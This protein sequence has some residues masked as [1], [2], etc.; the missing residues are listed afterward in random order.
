MN[1]A[2]CLVLRP[3]SE[4]FVVFGQEFR[5]KMRWRHQEGKQEAW[6]REVIFQQDEAWVTI[7]KDDMNAHPFIFGQFIHDAVSRCV[8]QNG[9]SK[10][11]NF[12][13][14]AHLELWNQY[15][16]T[17]DHAREASGSEAYP[18]QLRD[19]HL[20]VAEDR[21]NGAA[22]RASSQYQ[23]FISD[24]TPQAIRSTASGNK[25]WITLL[26]AW[27]RG[28]WMDRSNDWRRFAVGEKGQFSHLGRA[29]Q[30]CL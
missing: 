17:V 8:I 19:T 10:K 21:F 6:K 18:L 12:C 2:L 3:D 26:D 4:D 16:E 27:W 20:H 7:E 28:Y 22:D 13:K 11:F 1:V 5:M 30:A 14:F 29:I 15:V 23:T 9:R 25:R 24:S